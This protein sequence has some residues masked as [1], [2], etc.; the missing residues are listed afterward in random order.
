MIR[1]SLVKIRSSAS[2]FQFGIQIQ[3]CMELESSA[4]RQNIA[5]FAGRGREKSGGDPFSRGCTQHFSRYLHM[6]GTTSQTP[7]GSD[8]GKV[9]TT[10]FRAHE[11]GHERSES[12]PHGHG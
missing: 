4:I 10:Q 2:I 12:Y 5:F 8:C 1:F 9:F 3:D 6:P 7:S 11:A